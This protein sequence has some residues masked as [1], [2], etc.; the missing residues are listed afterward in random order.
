MQFGLPNDLSSFAGRL[1]DRRSR[2]RQRD[3][4]F[5]V[6]F[7]VAGTGVLSGVAARLEAL[8]LRA[9]RSRGRRSGLRLSGPPC[10]GQYGASGVGFRP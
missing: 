9:S 4:L 2:H 1:G 6:L 8:R 10:D 7:A 3:V 5:R